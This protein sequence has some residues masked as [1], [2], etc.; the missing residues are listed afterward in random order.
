MSQQGLPDRPFSAQSEQYY[1]GNG[2]YTPQPQYPPPY[3]HGGYGQQHPQQ[4]YTQP[5]YGYR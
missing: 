5:G 4:G 3:D 1:N 2:A